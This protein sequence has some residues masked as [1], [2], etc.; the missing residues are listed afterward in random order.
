MRKRYTSTGKHTYRLE[1]Y[2]ILLPR[3]DIRAYVLQVTV[4]IQRDYFSFLG[5][6]CRFAEGKCGHRRWNRLAEGF[7]YIGQVR[8][9]QRRD[10]GRPLLVLGGFRLS[11]GDAA[12]G[13]VVRCEFNGRLVLIGNIVVLANIVVVCKRRSW[14]LLCTFCDWGR[15][16][17]R[18][19]SLLFKT[20]LHSFQ[21]E[22]THPRACGYVHR[23]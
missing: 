1:V 7:F 13:S 16:R 2:W 3:N 18:M 4:V 5:F 14:C 17:A 19:R 22:F 9:D 8:H 23:R 11:V 12:A 20:F 21:Q 10:Y 15:R 6:A